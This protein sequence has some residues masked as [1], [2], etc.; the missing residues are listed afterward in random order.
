MD[1]DTTFEVIFIAVAV[2]ILAIVAVFLIFPVMLS[3][4]ISS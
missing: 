3:W 2:V 4:G 1:R